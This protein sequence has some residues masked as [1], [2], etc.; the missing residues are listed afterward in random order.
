M[1]IEII[2]NGQIVNTVTPPALFALAAAGTIGPET[3]IRINGK[4][5]TAGQLQ[6][7]VFGPMPLPGNGATYNVPHG[8]PNVLVPSNVYGY[9]GAPVSFQGAS[10]VPP[11]PTPSPIVY[12]SYG[13]PNTPPVV[14]QPVYVQQPVYT[15][16]PVQHADTSGA[17]VAIISLVMGALGL[18]AWLIPLVGFLIAVIG[19]V[20]GCIGLAGRGGRGLAIGGIILCSIGMIFSIISWIVNMIIL[21]NMGLL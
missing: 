9:G 16:Y 18:I 6:G 1:L 4:Y 5:G 10:N 12:G 20:C 15:P 3:T 14:H 17:G 13:V 21:A 2:E 19:I 11:P 7:L 8:V